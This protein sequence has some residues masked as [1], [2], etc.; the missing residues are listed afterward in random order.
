[1]YINM[2]NLQ[3]TSIKIQEEPKDSEQMKSM[4]SD[5]WLSKF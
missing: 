1:M 5:Q 4:K 3:E 2:Y